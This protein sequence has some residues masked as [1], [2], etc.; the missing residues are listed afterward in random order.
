MLG[1]DSS[2][3]EVVVGPSAI[4]APLVP[5]VPPVAPLT[6]PPNVSP[7]T[8]PSKGLPPAAAAKAPTYELDELFADAPRPNAT[9][10]LEDE[11][12][13]A[14]VLHDPPST[15]S[16]LFDADVFGAFALSPAPEK[17][18]DID[19]GALVAETPKPP[20][21]D[22]FAST[23]SDPGFEVDLEEAEPLPPPPFVASPARERPPAPAPP[24]QQPQQPASGAPIYLKG[25]K[26]SDGLGPVIGIDLG[27]TNS[28]C[29]VLTKGRPIIL[30]SKNGYNT[31]PSVVALSK[32][33]TLQVGHRARSQMVLNP[34][35]SIF[36]AK[37][38]VG[39]EFDSPTVKQVKER[40]HF[41]IVAGSDRRAAVRLG[42]RWPSRRWVR[43]S[44]APSS[45][46][47][48]IT[49]SRSARPYAA[50]APWPAS[51]SSA[52]STSPRPPRWRSA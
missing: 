8:T 26:P 22:L 51:R 24:P 45:P 21:E 1:K 44:R 37:R 3:P 16:A 47:P 52:C 10:P 48:L 17:E 43:P 32:D 19:L 27:T 36:G 29:A 5:V 33:G 25:I 31:I 7:R 23:E 12:F 18:I 11:P 13:E 28:A 20:A 4:V 46:A 14:P 9:Q 41:E 50:R 38:L 49:P 30:S 35:Q 2:S 15:A 39:R 34:T 42:A 40:S 6:A